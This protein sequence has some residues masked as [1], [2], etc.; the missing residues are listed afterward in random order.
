MGQRSR[1]WREEKFTPN[2]VKVVDC[3]G[4]T[5]KLFMQEKVIL[6]AGRSYEGASLYCARLGKVSLKFNVFKA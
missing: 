3:K 1:G 4:E 6:N 5:I 2:A